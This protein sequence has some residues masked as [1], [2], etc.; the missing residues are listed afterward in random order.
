MISR[1]LKSVTCTVRNVPEPALTP[2]ELELDQAQR[3]RI[4][5]EIQAA[6]LGN[7]KRAASSSS[8]K[9]KPTKQAKIA[10]LAQGSSLQPAGQVKIVTAVSDVQPLPGLAGARATPNANAGIVKR[11]V[12]RAGK[13]FRRHN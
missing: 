7:V 11:H 4:F 10:S 12:K 8:D 3:D 5:A 13:D 1:F 9:V 6:H 2:A